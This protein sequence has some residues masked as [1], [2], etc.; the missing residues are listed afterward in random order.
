MMSQAKERIDVGEFYNIRHI[1]EKIVNVMKGADSINKILLRE[2]M[3]TSKSLK[4]EADR[5]HL[6]KVEIYSLSN[7]IDYAVDLM[8]LNETFSDRKPGVPRII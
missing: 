5:G 8:V 2:L 6:Q 4:A 1:T 7:F 3:F